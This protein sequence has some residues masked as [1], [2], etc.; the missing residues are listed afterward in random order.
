MKMLVR[1][2]TN[3]RDALSCWLTCPAC[4]GRGR[5]DPEGVGFITMPCQACRGMGERRS[6]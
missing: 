5:L 1:I 2:V 6:N 3:L 4:G